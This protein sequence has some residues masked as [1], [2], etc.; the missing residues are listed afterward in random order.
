MGGA[1]SY[2]PILT[3]RLMLDCWRREYLPDLVAM[4]ADALVMKHFL[5]PL[6]PAESAAQYDRLESSLAERGFTFWPVIRRRDAQFLGIC[7]LKD[8]A[9]GTPI[10]D[11]LEI[12]WRFARHAWGQG[13][14]AEAARAA[15]AHGFGDAAV[16]RIAAITTTGNRPSWRVMER[17]GMVRAADEDFDHPM[18]PQ[19]HANQRHITHYVSRAAFQT[20]RSGG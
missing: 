5:A 6:T 4:N 16:M 17:I 14:A 8:G 3:E 1:V 12:G 13:F 7:G 11:E 10:E 20:G 9:P 2:V 19:G 18:M 15:L